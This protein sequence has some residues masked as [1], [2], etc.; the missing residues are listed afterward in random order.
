MPDIAEQIKAAR[1]ANG[2]SVRELASQAGVSKSLI[3]NIENNG[4]YSLRKLKIVA[5]ALGV[6]LEQTITSPE[7]E[8]PSRASVEAAMNLPIEMDAIAARWLRVFPLLP[9]GIRSTVLEE[10]S[11]WERKYGHLLE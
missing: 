3:S 2:L 1:L 11:L 9:S 7:A 5:E 6:Q 8:E 10:V 4:S